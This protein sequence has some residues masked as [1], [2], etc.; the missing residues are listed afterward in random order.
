MVLTEAGTLGTVTAAQTGTVWVTDSATGRVVFSSR[1]RQGDTLVV[2]PST[3]R[4]TYNA[5]P[6]DAYG[7]I[8]ARY[9][10]SFMSG[11]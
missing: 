6:V 5:R 10:V 11:S 4:I 2:D 8:P 1:M 9:R 7:N 3:N